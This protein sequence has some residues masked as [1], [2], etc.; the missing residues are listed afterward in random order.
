MNELARSSLHDG[1]ACSASDVPREHRAMRGAFDVSREPSVVRDD[2][3]DDT[4]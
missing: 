3:G 2:T 1:A 4:R